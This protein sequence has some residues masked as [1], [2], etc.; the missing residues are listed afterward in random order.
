MWWGYKI[1]ILLQLLLRYFTE[2]LTHEQ[3]DIENQ[4]FKVHEKI[5][6]F[7]GKVIQPNHQS[8]KIP[9]NAKVFC[10]SAIKKK[11]V[12]KVST[13]EA[14]KNGWQSNKTREYFD[15]DSVLEKF[16]LRPIWSNLKTQ[17]SD[18]VKKIQHPDS[19][20]QPY[21]SWYFHTPIYPLHYVGWAGRKRFK[22]LLWIGIG[23]L[24][25]DSLNI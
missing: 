3:I 20:P 2:P 25:F 23:N 1:I 19:N 4:N 24:H 22:N 18:Q 16:Q 6:N 15:Q 12:P 14:Y 7:K 8:E 21:A 11:L 17:E 9:T 10:G 5:V 13:I